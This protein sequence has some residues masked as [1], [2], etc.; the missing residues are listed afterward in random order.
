MSIC[1]QEWY[2]KYLI[3]NQKQIKGR[4]RDRILQIYLNHLPVLWFRYLVTFS[5]TTTTGLESNLSS[6]SSSLLLIMSTSYIKLQRAS[7]TYPIQVASELMFKKERKG[8]KKLGWKRGAWGFGTTGTIILY[9][10]HYMIF[11]C[12]LI[13]SLE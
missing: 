7:R 12:V 11:R 10:V 13:G 9:S 8:K 5:V 3:F 1:L 6:S 2:Q 4:E